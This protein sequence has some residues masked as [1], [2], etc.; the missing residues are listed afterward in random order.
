M[1]EQNCVFCKICRGESPETKIYYQDEELTVFMD[2]KP[3]TTHHY[4]VCTKQHIPDPKVLRKSDMGL[5]ERMMNVGM[6][7]LQ[8]NDGDTG[9]VRMGF[10]WPPFNAI[11]HLHLHV[12]SPQR[13][14]TL[15]SKAIFML[16]SL[17]FVSVKW[18]MDHLSA[19]EDE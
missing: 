17:W 8:E 4:L 7:V 6:Q 3:A 1:S 10:H 13:Q 14:M 12:I 18:L 5:V 19:M 9:D 15:I 11:C 16:N 2:H